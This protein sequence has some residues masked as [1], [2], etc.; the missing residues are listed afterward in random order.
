VSQKIIKQIYFVILALTCFIVFTACR[1]RGCKDKDAE[2]F[3]PKA[4]N[5]CSCC[6]FTGKA[7]IWYEKA[8]YD[9]LKAAGVSKLTYYTDGEFGGET[10]S[11]IPFYSA[12]NNPPTISSSANNNN[13][14]SYASYYTKEHGEA[15]IASL[16]ADKQ[17]LIKI[18]I[19]DQNGVIRWTGSATFKANN[20]ITV[21]CE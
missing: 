4:S 20:V 1:S 18:D 10:R 19:K 21:K 13:G 12:G 15:M 14:E 3:E 7:V 16:G 8:F 17:K 2:N 5:D 9:K 11:S 6:Y